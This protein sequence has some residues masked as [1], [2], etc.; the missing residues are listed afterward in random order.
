MVD[1]GVVQVDVA[2]VV[3]VTIVVVDAVA[4]VEVRDVMVEVDV[5]AVVLATVVLAHPCPGR[6]LASGLTPSRSACRSA[7][8]AMSRGHQCGWCRAAHSVRWRA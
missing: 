4:E 7:G 5:V 8:T 1:D 2:V 6:A 3:V